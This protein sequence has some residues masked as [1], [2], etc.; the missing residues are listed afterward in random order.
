MLPP[1]E[2]PPASDDAPGDSFDDAPPDDL[3]VEI[4]EQAA[5]PGFDEAAIEL[6]PG[7]FA[8][9]PVP[10]FADTVEPLDA[11]ALLADLTPEQA[12]AVTHVDGPLLVIAAAGSGKTRVLTRRVVYLIS[13]GIDPGSILAITFT[14]KA[15]GEMKERVGKLLGR[16]LRD[17][18]RLEPFQPTICTFHS[19]CMR[20]L[21]TYGAQIGLAGVTIFDTS[22]QLKVVK[23]ALKLLDLSAT[24]FAPSSV[25][26][27][28]S[29]AKNQLLGPAQFKSN[30]GDFFQRQVARVYEKYQSMLEAQGALDFD[31]LLLRTVRAF[32]EQ[33][34]V[35]EDLQRRFQYLLIDEYQDTNHAQ[36]VLSSA[37]ALRHRNLCVVGD[38]DQS[39]YAWRGADLQN[40]LD[41]KSDYPDCKEVKLEKN[42][43]SSQ[44]I[45]DVADKLIKHNSRR[46]DK[47]LLTDNPAGEKVKLVLCQDEHDEA[48]VVHRELKGLHDREKIPWGKMAVFYRMNSLSRVMEDALRRG[49]V[50]YVIARGTA[51]YERKEIK[52]ALSYLRVIANPL[53]E[54]SLERMVNTPPRGI[55][56]ASIDKARA[57][58]V[59]H[60]MTLFQAL[61]HA[62]RIDALSARA[63]NAIKSLLTQVQGWQKLASPRAAAAVN[64]GPSPAAVAIAAAGSPVPPASPGSPATAPDTATPAASSDAIPPRKRKRAERV[65]EDDMFTALD[66]AGITPAHLSAAGL[67]IPLP[68]PAGPASVSPP[69]ASAESPARPD[70]APAS[71]DLARTAAAAAPPAGA[72]VPV[73]PLG[74]P[75]KGTIARLLEAVIKQSGLEAMYAKESRS[76]EDTGEGPL[77]NLAELITDAAEF[78]TENPDGTLDDYLTKTALV[79]DVDA[80][81]DASGEGA[82]TM[83]TLHAAKGLEFPVVAMIGLEEGILPHSRARANVDELEE[84]RR[85]AFVGITR[86]QDRLLLTKAAQRTIRG[87]RERTITSP[88]LSEIPP[89]RVEV[90]DRAG[91]APPTSSTAFS[92][93]SRG[94]A[95]EAANAALADGTSK[96]VLG[97]R[98]RPGQLVRHPAF[99]LGRIAEL[100]GSGSQTRCIVDFNS[101]GRKTLILEYAKLEVV[102]L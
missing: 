39:I 4:P 74:G 89:D 44:T 45:L 57:W 14:N 48:D 30:A 59:S 60:G 1:P 94:A 41:F 86:A 101:A 91:F 70:A 6:P 61:A 17:F 22:D 9:S 72:G 3:P 68:P 12:E 98:Y 18:G 58:A 8:D 15:A 56:D 5:E 33:P 34:D 25:L 20:I 26:S 55:G 88:F 84:E 31:D 42:Y 2:H 83:M 29:N 90:H 92:H 64:S 53:D 50:P 35:L 97:R 65:E 63:R 24:N 78:D 28:I 27:S 81:K 23:E 16:R 80:I 43:R 82:V 102:E 67:A 46:I 95:R 75:V 62:D 87:L 76:S 69:H 10:T 49:G 21:R 40:I 100:S 7:T 52:D 96:T 77:A 71:A 37:L 51:F 73:A 13:Q 85:L 66:K 11:A 79:A 38:P 19:L 32:K 99:G 54:I 47:A 93:L 36:Y